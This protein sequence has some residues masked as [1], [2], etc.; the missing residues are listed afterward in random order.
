MRGWELR[1]DKELQSEESDKV[2]KRV[3]AGENLLVRKIS[4]AFA[5]IHFLHQRKSYSYSISDP[6]S[7]QI[8]HFFLRGNFL[9]IRF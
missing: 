3:E 1:S 7:P 6:K 9:K 2:I 8:L 5:L 4:R